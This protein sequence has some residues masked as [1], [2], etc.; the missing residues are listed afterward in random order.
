M[1]IDTTYMTAQEIKD[2]Q[3]KVACVQ[4]GSKEP[5]VDMQDGL[6]ER[7]VVEEEQ[8]PNAQQSI[9]KYL[10]KFKTHTQ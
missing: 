3:V 9:E 2:L 1:A 6:C 8:P 10:S 7:C 4:C 5:E